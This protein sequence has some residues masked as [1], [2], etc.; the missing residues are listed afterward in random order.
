MQVVCLHA[1]LD[2]PFSGA[3]T[4]LAVKNESAASSSTQQLLLQN[5]STLGIKYLEQS[6]IHINVRFSHP[7]FKL[8]FLFSILA[9]CIRD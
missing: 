2:V 8:L 4:V 1:K 7:Q 6:G 9:K 3:G 5:C